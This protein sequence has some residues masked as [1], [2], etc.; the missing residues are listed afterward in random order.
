MS[1][2]KKY[3]S[4][5]LRPKRQCIARAALEWKF[6]HLDVS[7]WH[8]C[9]LILT[10]AELQLQCRGPGISHGKEVGLRGWSLCSLWKLNFW[11]HELPWI[12]MIWYICRICHLKSVSSRFCRLLWE[13]LLLEWSVS[14]S[15]HYCICTCLLVFIVATAKKDIDYRLSWLG[16]F[17]SLASVWFH[18][19]KPPF[20]H[21]EQK[22]SRKVPCSS[23]SN[24]TL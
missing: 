18:Y 21:S 11:C 13:G 3:M 16:L 23:N 15:E 17:R 19:Y 7:R 20:H 14:K 9:D 2:V 12:A 4:K 1:T 8:C 5:Q 10:G 24:T 22:A 6:Q